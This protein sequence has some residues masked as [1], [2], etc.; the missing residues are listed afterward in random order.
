MNSEEVSWRC[1]GISSWPLSDRSHTQNLC[2]KSISITEH[3]LGTTSDGNGEKSVAECVK[4]GGGGWRNGMCPGIHQVL[5]YI[6][7]KR[8]SLIVVAVA[9]ESYSLLT[10]VIV[11][12]IVSVRLHP[13]ELKIQ[14]F[15][16]N[17][18]WP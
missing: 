2:R 6:K 17:I 13:V 15:L 11:D 4:G 12:V 1:C 7:H 16:L 3:S 10:R 9:V 8:L 14:L 5:L 18:S